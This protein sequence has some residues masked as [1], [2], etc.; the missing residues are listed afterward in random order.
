L[1][2]LN[3][4]NTPLISSLTTVE[5]NV[6]RSIF[7][8][9]RIKSSLDA[10]NEASSTE[11][12]Q[13][14]SDIK[15][16]NREHQLICTN[17]SAITIVTDDSQINVLRQFDQPFPTPADSH[18]EIPAQQQQRARISSSDDN[19]CVFRDSE[20]T[21]MSKKCDHLDAAL[22]RERMFSESLNER[23]TLCNASHEKASKTLAEHCVYLQELLD[24]SLHRNSKLEE[25]I[26]VLQGSCFAACSINLDDELEAAKRKVLALEEI[27]KELDKA[28]SGI[29]KSPVELEANQ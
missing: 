11:I 27:Q 9:K 20:F 6:D 10:I 18:V 29:K 13:E 16:F 14:E 8:P 23:L 19:H 5:S 4:I 21:L 28:R 1:F 7:E 2:R 22:T 12:L 26:R 25:Q 15:L 17:P 3:R 24:V